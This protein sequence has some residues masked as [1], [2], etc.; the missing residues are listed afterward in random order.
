MATKKEKE[1]KQKLTVEEA[2]AQIE[3][4]I[5]ALESD[6]ITLEDSFKELS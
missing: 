1:E 2:F 4:K 6:D 3:E 5:E